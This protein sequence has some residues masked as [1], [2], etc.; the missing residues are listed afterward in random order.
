MSNWQPPGGESGKSYIHRREDGFFARWLAGP[1]ILDV[2]CGAAG[3]VLPWGLAST[4]AIRAM[5]A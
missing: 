4:K 1:M 3:P 5:T 2:G